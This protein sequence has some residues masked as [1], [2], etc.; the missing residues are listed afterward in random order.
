M[1]Y[2]YTYLKNDY[3]IEESNKEL[4]K[5]KDEKIDY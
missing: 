5:L 3:D 2:V 4:R 1:H